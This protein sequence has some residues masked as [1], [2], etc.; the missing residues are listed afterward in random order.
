MTFHIYIYIYIGN[1]IIP[2][3]ELYFSEGFVGHFPSIFP[4]I[5]HRIPWVP[6]REPRFDPSGDVL[7]R[8]EETLQVDGTLAQ[9]G[10]TGSARS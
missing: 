3:D 6:S 4:A 8:Q 2:T 9:V 1:V 10:S 7:K 5:H